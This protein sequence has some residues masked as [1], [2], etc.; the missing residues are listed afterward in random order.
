MTYIDHIINLS[1]L[2]QMSIISKYRH[3][4]KELPS[5]QYILD[6][7]INLPMK[8]CNPEDNKFIDL[9]YALFRSELNNKNIK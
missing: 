2:V 9:I 5:S 6:I 7:I 4:L 3:I 8:D 1:K